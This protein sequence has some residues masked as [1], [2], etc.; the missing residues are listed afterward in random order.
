MR[1][2]LII[3]ILLIMYSQLFTQEKRYH[4]PRYDPS[5]NAQ[6]DLD[7]AIQQAKLQEKRIL[8][9][10]GGE[11]C[12]WCRR[13]DSLFLNDAELLSY[14]Q[15][16]YIFLKINVSKENRNENVLSKFPK[17]PG[18]PHFFVLDPTGKMLHSQSTEEFE[19]PSSLQHKGH[20]KEKVLKFLQKWSVKKIRRH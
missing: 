19:T 8:V 1:K 7:S 20:E 13:L 9:L 6:N 3:L 12:I 4:Y 2:Y 10:V 15:D 14:L 11:W 16:Y 5:R 17:I 18:Y